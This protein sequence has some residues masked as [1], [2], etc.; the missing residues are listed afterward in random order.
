MKQAYNN[1]GIGLNQEPLFDDI[2][3]Y[4]ESEATN[5]IMK[6]KQQARLPDVCA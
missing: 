5:A 2:I 3:V 6:L 1:L 4:S